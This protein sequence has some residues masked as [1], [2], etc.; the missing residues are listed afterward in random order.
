[1]PMKNFEIIAKYCFLHGTVGSRRNGVAHQIRV[2]IIL[3]RFA[4]ISVTVYEYIEMFELVS[5]DSNN[6]D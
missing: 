5:V 1:M 2:A 3:N 6:Q 4:V